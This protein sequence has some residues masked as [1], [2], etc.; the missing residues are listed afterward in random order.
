M[1]PSR[2]LV[3][4][5]P[6]LIG[7]GAERVCVLMANEMAR[8]GHKVTLL[9]WNKDGPNAD[10]VDHKVRLVSLDLAAHHG[11]FGKIRTLLGVL[12]TGLFL[13]RE[14]PD[15]VFAYLEFANALTAISL[16]AAG[17]RALFFPSYHAAAELQ[18]R[19]L[20]YKVI[21]LFD[22]LTIKR[23]TRA[24]GVSAG[25]GRDL[26]KRGFDPG[27]VVVIHNPVT[28]HARLNPE[29]YAWE[30]ALAAFG[31]GPVII[32]LGRLVSVK[33]HQTLLRAFSR[34]APSRA[35]KLVVFGEGPLLSNLESLAYSLGISDRVLFAGY[36]ND[37]AACYACGDIFVLS[38]RTEGFGN[39]LVE[40]MTF[41]LSVVS[42]DAP[43]GPREILD[44]G[45]FGELVPVGDADA[46]AK[47]ID[48]AIE[49][50]HDREALKA[51]ARDFDITAI[52]EQYERLC[53]N[54]R[55]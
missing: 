13:R 1:K 43:Y 2:H 30:A 46:L 4:H 45:K 19:G 38:S 52:G 3:F 5:V 21:K 53:F 28:C 6:A 39:A 35:A 41:G 44:H 8:R 20:A 37:P 33:D 14:S 23:A 18:V 47:A 11:K 22:R 16:L 55:G 48:R 54:V 32:T 49:A 36:V 17:S 7:G 25:I 51:R 9:V 50:S 15:A 34:L 27:N 31:A 10:M 12:K 29:P 24:I 42:T 40:A 26:V